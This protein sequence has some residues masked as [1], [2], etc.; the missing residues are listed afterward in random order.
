MKDLDD[1]LI[2]NG[3][4]T[5]TWSVGHPTYD[6]EYAD[7][8]L[9]IS[10]TTPQLQKF[11][12]L[13]E[14][15][16]ARYGMSLNET[17][18]EYLPKPGTSGDLIFKSQDKVPKVEKVKYLGSVLRIKAAYY[19]RIPNT[20]VWERAGR[21]HRAGDILNATQHKMLVEV[22]S[23][24]M[25]SPLHNVVFCSALKDRIMSQGRRRGK[26]IPY[27]LNTIVKRHYPNLSDHTAG[28]YFGPQFKYVEL[29]RTLRQSLERAPKRAAQRAWP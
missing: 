5:N 4:P 20:E 11:L 22:Y 13:L 2:A 15:E 10:L 29:G 8:T 24:S 18:T 14:E 19:S 27:W 6:M 9:P 21:P 16:A 23:H 12:T 17:K 3:V 28:K 25:E 7:D 1:K 26:P